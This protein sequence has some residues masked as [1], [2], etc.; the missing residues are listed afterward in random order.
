[1]SQC[2][3]FCSFCHSAGKPEEVY[4]S[5]WVKDKIGGDVVCPALLANEC[6]YCHD[7]GHT[8]RFCPKLKAKEARRRRRAKAEAGGWSKPKQTSRA[9]N[10]EGKRPTKITTNPFAALEKSVGGK[11]AK[12]QAV[13][14]PRACKP[15]PPQGAWNAAHKAEVDSLKA[16]LE[17][18]RA[19][20]AAAEQTKALKAHLTEV[21]IL[22]K[23]PE[24]PAPFS[25]EAA[26]AE[27]IA[28]EIAPAAEAA[29]AEFAPVPL[30]EGGD[31]LADL[32]QSPSGDGWGSDADE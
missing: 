19:K 18:M 15:S 24:P 11:V 22:N 2:K 4:T 23:E 27:A 13:R 30:P 20:L 5:H 31:F 32:G 28:A 9:R 16:E 25:A 6:G 10:A 21:G 29:P 14:G 17:A 8:P 7:V 26:A 3:M 12:P 1:M